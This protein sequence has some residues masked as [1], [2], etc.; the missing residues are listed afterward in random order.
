MERLAW[1]EYIKKM[2]YLVVLVVD[3]SPHVAGD[4]I[5]W[6]PE[7]S[8][9]FG[10]KMLQHPWFR[11]I[12]APD[13]SESECEA[14][15][16]HEPGDPTINSRLLIREFKLDLAALDAVR[17]TALQAPKPPLA[18]KWD[19]AKGLPRTVEDLTLTAAQVLALK[20]QK[21]SQSIDIGNPKVIG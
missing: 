9:S 17:K 12:Y 3:N 4:V 7:G 13:L 18:V 5:S 20:V 2:P 16:S 6:R 21:P 11:V 15:V 19:I 1:S 8:K 14:L 10:L